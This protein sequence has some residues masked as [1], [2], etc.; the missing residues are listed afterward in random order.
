MNCFSGGFTAPSLPPSLGLSVCRCV[1][2]LLLKI[3]ILLSPQS[4]GTVCRSCSLWSIVSPW[5]SLHHLLLVSPWLQSADSVH[6][7]WTTLCSLFIFRKHFRA[8][9]SSCTWETEREGEGVEGSI[10]TWSEN[11]NEHEAEA[12]LFSHCFYSSGPEQLCSSR[13]M[14]RGFLQEGYR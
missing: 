12:T 14:H 9:W 7:F 2:R 11:K 1:I 8:P 10:Q 3:I 6:L 5:T 13:L 4:A